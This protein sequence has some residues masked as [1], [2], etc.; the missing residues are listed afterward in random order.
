MTLKL[1]T[2]I[3]MM[4]KI[5]KIAALIL[6]LVSAECGAQEYLTGFTAG[7]ENRVKSSAN[8]TKTV[9]ELPFF[10]DFSTAGI[11]PDNYLWQNRAVFVNSGF[12]VFPTNFQAATFDALDEYGAVYGRA[13]SSPFIADSLMSV[14]INMSGYTPAD[15]VYLSFFYQPQGRGDAPESTD[16][17]VCEMGFYDESEDS[18]KFVHLWSKPGI[19]LDAFLNEDSTHF[20]REVRIPIVDSVLFSEKVYLLFYNY[21]SLPPAMYPNDRSNVDQWSI[22]YVRLAANRTS[23]GEGDRKMS[24]SEYAP[25][26]LKRYTSMPYRQYKN[27]PTAFIATSV[28]TY[29]ANLDT[30]TH[31]FVYDF[32]AEEIDGAWSFTQE[33]ETDFL[34]ADTLAEHKMTLRNFLFPFNNN[35]DTASFLVHHFV[36]PVDYQQ[37]DGDSLVTVQKF[38]NYYSY[39]DGVP[40]SGYGVTPDESSFAVQFNASLPDTIRGVDILFNRTQNDANYNFFDIVI[41]G[42]NNGKP[43]SEI[44]RLA[45]Q[46]PI[47]SDDEIYKFGYYEFPE[48]VNVVGLFYVGIMQQES[49]TINIGFDTSEDNSEYNFY[50]VG[51]GWYNSSFPG[52]V[53]LRP[54]VGGDFHIGVAEN[55]YLAGDISVYPNPARDV[56]YV[57]SKTPVVSVSIYDISGRLVKVENGCGK[58]SVSEL[59]SGMYIVRIVDSEGQTYRKLSIE[60]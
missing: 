57:S 13:S 28:T 17:L 9:I 46:R 34:V 60:R 16:S 38:Y 59:G 12:P 55:D 23:V 48:T 43:G 20:F 51:Y 45:D 11:Y 14:A 1:M 36:N 32:A 50:N 35:R 24:F 31:Q 49:M 2:N 5:S 41:W 33:D 21:A 37:A 4:K 22:D 39:D 56:F 26:L 25:S 44:Y 6:L 52:S 10:D 54:V 42:D 7:A 30:V 58:I 19:T 27:N 18:V 3:I 15:S 53:M 40:E 47:W 8:T 29:I